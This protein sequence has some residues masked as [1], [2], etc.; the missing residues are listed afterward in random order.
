MADEYIVQHNTLVDIADAIREKRGIASVMALTDMP[1]QIRNIKTSDGS[2]DTSGIDDWIVAEA[3]R[4]VNIVNG[5]QATNSNL[6]TFIA[7][8]DMHEPGD[9]DLSGNTTTINAYRLANQHAAQ[10]IKL[11]ANGLNSLDFITNLGDYSW[12]NNGTNPTTPLDWMKS[13]R[14]A[15]NYIYD[16]TC[17]H[18]SFL[19]PGNH[20]ALYNWQSTDG[21]FVSGEIAKGLIGNYNYQ[22]FTSKKIRVIALNTS[23]REASGNDS[24]YL[25]TTQLQWFANSLDLSSKSNASDW[26]IIILSHTPIGYT[27]YSA[28]QS[29]AEIVQAYINGSSITIGGTVYNFSGKNSAKIISNIHGH[30]HCFKVGEILLNGASLGTSYLVQR[31][32]VP[33][34]CKGRTNEYYWAY[35]NPNLDYAEEITCPSTAATNGVKGF[36]ENDISQ[37][38]TA[39]CVFAI[40]LTNKNIYSYCFGSNGE[41]EPGTKYS[42]YDRIIAYGE[43]APEVYTVT[44][45]LTNITASGTSTVTAGTSYQTILTPASN[46]AIDESSIVVTMDGATVTNYSYNSSTGLLTIGNVSGDIIIT[47]AATAAATYSITYSLDDGMSSSASTTSVTAGSTYSTTLTRNDGY[48]VNDSVVVTM[49]GT[50]ITPSYGALDEN[51]NISIPE[52][53]GNVIIT[54]VTGTTNLPDLAVAQD[55]GEYNGGLGYKNNTRIT[56]TSESFETTESGYTVTGWIRYLDNEVDSNDCPTDTVRI[57]TIAC[58]ESTT[59]NFAD[60]RNCRLYFFNEDLTSHCVPLIYGGGSENN[61]IE[62]FYSITSQIIDGRRIYQFDPIIENGKW[63]AFDLTGGAK[64][65]NDIRYFKLCLKGQGKDIVISLREP[66]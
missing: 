39:F 28:M 42:G 24:H 36:T 53:T 62:T 51:I 32:A 55:G 26:S 29:A 46:Y 6:L 3:E 52:V 59:F 25:S 45:N 13:I 44:Y 60:D 47:A 50:D 54:A 38:D 12:G 41:T 34:A 49:G 4:I 35:D 23:E 1:D 30:T 61:N 8:S 18:T 58:D 20:D 66:E 37:F 63:K 48:T 11:I 10:G 65:A 5:L 9:S 19:L 15:T 22:D 40:D 7:V 14:A 57:I 21:T 2:I 33:C 64:P 31:I 56:E 16:T 43:A 27:T 17:N